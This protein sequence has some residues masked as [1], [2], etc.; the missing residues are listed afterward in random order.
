MGDDVLLFTGA[1][2]LMGFFGGLVL[3]EVGHVLGVLVLGLLGLCVAAVLGVFPISSDWW[4]TFAEGIAE[5]TPMA[6]TIA[7]H[8]QSLLQQLLSRTPKMGPGALIVGMFAGLLSR[9]FRR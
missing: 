1:L 6:R 4:P 8:V 5:V 9:R 3:A 2:A 7:E